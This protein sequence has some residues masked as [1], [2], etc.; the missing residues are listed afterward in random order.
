[1]KLRTL[2]L[3]P[4]R[5]QCINLYA[6]LSLRNRA[7]SA[8]SARQAA[9]ELLREKGRGARREEREQ[10]EKRKGHRQKWRKR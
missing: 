9:F 8:D 4:K 6:S 3:C 1:L 7:H 10:E 2:F 5:P